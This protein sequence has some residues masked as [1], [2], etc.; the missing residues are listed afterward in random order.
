VRNTPPMKIIESVWG[1]APG[2]VQSD[3]RN[4]LVL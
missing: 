1:P 2:K 4:V 3:G